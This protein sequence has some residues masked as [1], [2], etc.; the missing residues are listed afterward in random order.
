VR[1]FHLNNFPGVP[2]RHFFSNT[3]SVVMNLCDFQVDVPIKYLN[4]FLEDD[5]E[6]ER[7]KLVLL[8][9]MLHID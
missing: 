4:F 2:V 3:K 8:Q 6:L 1:Y 5:N 7:I 9:T